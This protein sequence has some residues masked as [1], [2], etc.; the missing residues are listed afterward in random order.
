MLASAD[1]AG[2]E[3]LTRPDYLLQRPL[4][5]PLHIIYS[6]ISAYLHICNEHKIYQRL[7]GDFLKVILFVEKI[8]SINKSI[9]NTSVVC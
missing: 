9:S 2:G 4:L 7:P 1:G 5:C 6:A 8:Q 3:M